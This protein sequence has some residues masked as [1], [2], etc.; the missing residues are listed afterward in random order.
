MTTQD[1][2]YEWYVTM[3]KGSTYKDTGHFNVQ[4]LA[5]LYP[6]DQVIEMLIAME[7]SSEIN[8]DYGHVEYWVE[9]LVATYGKV[10]EPFAR[11]RL[12]EP[13]HGGGTAYGEKRLRESE[14]RV[15]RFCAAI[16]KALGVP[17]V[18]A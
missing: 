10:L 9:H 17:E 4:E 1:D 5:E 7:G 2:I 14:H 13:L 11:L 6:A 15:R 3:A 18:I 16:L 12:R 8:W